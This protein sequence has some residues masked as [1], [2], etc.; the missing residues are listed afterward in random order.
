MVVTVG[1]TVGLETFD[2]KPAGD[3]VHEY[4][5]PAVAAPPMVVELPLQIV[6]LVPAAAGGA[7]L[8]VMTTELVLLQP[9]AVMVCTNVYVVVTV[10]ETLGLEAVDV[11]P[12]GLDVQL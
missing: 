12:L 8:T 6:A 4:V 2:V 5:L 9:V 11:K 3:E 1:A 10:G 7:G